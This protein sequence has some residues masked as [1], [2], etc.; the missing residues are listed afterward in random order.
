MF[1]CKFVRNFE[2]VAVPGPKSLG[3]SYKNKVYIQNCWKNNMSQLF[4][5]AQTHLLS[6]ILFIYFLFILGYKQK[7]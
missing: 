3:F 5:F 4:F 7:I 1:S 6:F 2:M